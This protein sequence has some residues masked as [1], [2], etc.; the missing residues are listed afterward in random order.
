VHISELANYRVPTVE[1]VVHIGDE[2]QVLVTEIDRQGRVNLSRRA[3]L[4]P[5]EDD[6]DGEDDHGR[7][8]D[9]GERRPRPFNERRGRDGDRGYRNGG[10]GHRE[11]APHHEHESSGASESTAEA[12]SSRPKRESSGTRQRGSASGR[13]ASMRADSEPQA[14]DPE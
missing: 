6:H 4:E 12:S 2:V 14:G 9:T 10:G 11:R 1:D 3:L 5:S 8:G 13:R 7:N